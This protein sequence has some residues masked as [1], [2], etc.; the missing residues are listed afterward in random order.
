MTQCMTDVTGNTTVKKGMLRLFSKH[1][2]WCTTTKQEYNML[3]CSIAGVTACQLQ[4]VDQVFFFNVGQWSFFVACKLGSSCLMAE[5]N[6]KV[7]LFCLIQADADM[8]SCSCDVVPGSQGEKGGEL[9]HLQPTKTLLSKNRFHPKHDSLGR[10]QQDHPGLYS[11]TTPLLTTL[12]TGLTRSSFRGFVSIALNS[13]YI[14]A[15]SSPN[16]ICMHLTKSMISSIQCFF[17]FEG[18]AKIRNS[19]ETGNFLYQSPFQEFVDARRRPAIQT[20]PQIL[21]SNREPPREINHIP[22]LAATENMGYVTFGKGRRTWQ[23]VLFSQEHSYSMISCSPSLCLFSPSLRRLCECFTVEGHLSEVN[24]NRVFVGRKSR[25]ILLLLMFITTLKVKETLLHSLLENKIHKSLASL[26]T[27]HS[28]DTWCFHSPFPMAVDLVFNFRS[29]FF[30]LFPFV[31]CLI[32]TPN[33]SSYSMEK[34]LNKGHFSIA[35]QKKHLPVEMDCQPFSSFPVHGKKV[36]EG[37][38]NCLN[39]DGKSKFAHVKAV[40]MSLGCTYSL[41]L[42]SVR[43]LLQRCPRSQPQCQR[44]IEVKVWQ[45]WQNNL[46]NS[47][48]KRMLKNVWIPIYLPLFEPDSTPFH[49]NWLESAKPHP[50]QGLLKGIRGT[51]CYHSR[52]KPPLGLCLGAVTWAYAYS[53]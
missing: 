42:T 13:R 3:K 33:I 12:Q 16:S 45:S 8:L 32:Q 48:L 36:F 19:P 2:T 18:I 15:N 31:H 40:N 47:R 5:L 39:L 4:A 20:A 50:V 51:Y 34:C 23:L 28:A 49:G 21:Y 6:A 14:Q 11:V 24:D 30:S 37:R 22:G 35:H 41:S 43:L 27:S 25:L 7:Q 1:N 29:D 53:K 52:E 44:I 38:C 46:Q 17:L 9:I 10:P 26:I